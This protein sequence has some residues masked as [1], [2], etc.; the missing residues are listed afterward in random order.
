MQIM[1]TIDKNKVVIIS[2]SNLEKTCKSLVIKLAVVV[3]AFMG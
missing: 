1:D 2:N 3:M